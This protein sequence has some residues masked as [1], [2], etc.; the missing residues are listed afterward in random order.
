MN[1]CESGLQWESI[2]H[3]NCSYNYRNESLQGFFFTSDRFWSSLHPHPAA[4]PVCPKAQAFRS[5]PTQSISIHLTVSSQW[6]TNQLLQQ[7]AGNQGDGHCALERQT[8]RGSHV[9]HLSL[10][11]PL[12]PGFSHLAVCCYNSQC[13]HS[14]MIYI[15]L[16]HAAFQDMLFNLVNL[17]LPDKGV[18]GGGVTYQSWSNLCR[19]VVLL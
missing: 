1:F 17:S 16:P 10:H 7:P 4:Q 19:L 11:H 3:S 2:F 6:R 13:K 12:S 14:L 5:S 8:N 9:D 15:C 18:V